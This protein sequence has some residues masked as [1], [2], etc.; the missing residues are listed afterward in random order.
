MNIDNNNFSD[1]QYFVNLLTA[2]N[3]NNNLVLDEFK[4]LYVIT[5]MHPNSQEYQQLFENCKSN[6]DTNQSKLFTISNDIQSNT[7][8]LNQ[9]LIKLNE[10][11]KVERKKNKELKT[12]L[13]MVEHKNN[14]ASEMIN[15]YKEMYDSKYLRNWSLILS[16]FI[17][18]YAI[19]LVYKK[20]NIV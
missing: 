6:I 14:S 19:N 3:E 10:Q 13:G 9:I 11:I 15:N 5:N 12:K 18:I 1:K 7:N 2:L 20:Q 8:K 17:C 16:T 4:K